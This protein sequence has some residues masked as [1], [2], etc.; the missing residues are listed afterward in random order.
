MKGEMMFCYSTAQSSTRLHRL[1]DNCERPVSSQL[2]LNENGAKF[3]F[4]SVQVGLNFGG[5]DAK[6]V[7]ATCRG[8]EPSTAHAPSY[9]GY[10]A[11][12]NSENTMQCVIPNFD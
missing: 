1:R 3:Y 7:T 2:G 5:R 10:I 12:K 4:L 6:Y 9:E 11:T 8:T